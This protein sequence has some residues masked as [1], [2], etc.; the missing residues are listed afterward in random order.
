LIEKSQNEGL[1]HGISIAT[2]APN[3]S[4][5]LYA[6]DS[7]L[8]CS[9]KPE[10]ARVIMNIL[11]LYQEASGQRVNMEK[12]EMTFSP[13]I[14]MEHK[15]KFQDNL[16]ISISNHIHKYLGMPTHF[17]RSK[18]QDFQYIMDRVWKKLKGWKEKSLSFEGRGVLI[19]V[20]AQAIPTYIMSYFLLP[21]GLCEKIEK[22]CLFFLVG[23]F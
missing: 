21:K 6:D 9:A 7:I 18:E 11:T 3:I 12:F 1:I 5:L 10:E 23:K 16:P 22:N 15:K 19:R 8:F 20:V 17:G 2:N 13:N 14:S 4:H